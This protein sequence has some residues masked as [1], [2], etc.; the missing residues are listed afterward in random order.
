MR[1]AAERRPVLSLRRRCPGAWWGPRPGSAHAWGESDDI[2]SQAVISAHTNPA[3]SLAMAVTTRLRLV[4][5]SSRRRKRPHRR[6]C[7]AQANPYL[8]TY[9]GP[10]PL[11]ERRLAVTTCLSVVTD[12]AS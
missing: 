10:K 7:A 12:F 5:R 4:L 9:G 8:T 1:F 3:S 6:S 11:L 2:A